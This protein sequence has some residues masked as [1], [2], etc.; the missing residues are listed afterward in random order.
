M[1]P[2]PVCSVWEKDEDSTKA[3]RLTGTMPIEPQKVSIGG[4]TLFG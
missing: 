3:E 4:V 2:V 1:P